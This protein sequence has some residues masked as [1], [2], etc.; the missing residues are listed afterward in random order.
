MIKKL[1]RKR[2]K[3][4]ISEMFKKYNKTFVFSVD[5]PW[6]ICLPISRST[7]GTFMTMSTYFKIGSWHLFWCLPILRSAVGTFVSMSTYFKIGS[8]HFCFG[9]YIF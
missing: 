1:I 3:I 6:F 8:R 2:I 5:F 7:V 4:N 9:V